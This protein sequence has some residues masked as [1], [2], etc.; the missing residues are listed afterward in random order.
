M[1]LYDNFKSIKMNKIKSPKVKKSPLL[2][3]YKKEIEKSL[4]N[5]KK[6][7][8]LSN[9]KG[10]KKKFNNQN[11]IIPTELNIISNINSIIKNTNSKKSKSKSKS[12]SKSNINKPIINDDYKKTKSDINIPII[13]KYSKKSINKKSKKS[14]NKDKLNINKPINKYSKKYINK[15]SKKS[16]NKK[17]INKKYINK[18]SRTISVKLNNKENNIKEIINKFNNM[19]INDIQKKL[20]SKGIYS[21]NNNKDKLLKYMYLLTCVDDNINIIKN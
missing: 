1:E 20:E 10:K 6:I 17:S 15:K 18:K 14:I 7:K 12:R 13:N 21:K 8:I 11:S 2:K 4:K 3:D 9:K 16:I 19:D 5:P